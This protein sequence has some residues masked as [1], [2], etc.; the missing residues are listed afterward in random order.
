[1]KDLAFLKGEMKVK[2]RCRHVNFFSIEPLG[3]YAGI[4]TDAIL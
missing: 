2:M 4:E 1:M 3:Q